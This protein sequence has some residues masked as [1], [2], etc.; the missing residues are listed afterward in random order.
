MKKYDDLKEENK[1]EETTKEETKDWR[2]KTLEAN[3]FLCK[4]QSATN[5]SLTIDNFS[6]P[7][8]PAA[9]VWPKHTICS[10]NQAW[11][12]TSQGNTTVPGQKREGR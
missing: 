11:L 6:V 2:Q 9:E 3:I 1:P 7:Q 5:C 8:S 10:R 4:T 12:K